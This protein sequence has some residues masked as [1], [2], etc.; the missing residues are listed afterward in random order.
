VYKGATEVTANPPSPIFRMIPPLF[1][2]KSTYASDGTG[3]RTQRRRSTI[4]RGD[5]APCG[6]FDMHFAYCGG[7]FT[8]ES[9]PYASD[10]IRRPAG[11]FERYARGVR[12]CP[13]KI[14]QSR[15]RPSAKR[16]SRECNST[17][18]RGEALLPQVL[19]RGFPVTIAVSLIVM[20]AVLVRVVYGIQYDSDDIPSLKL[21]TSSLSYVCRC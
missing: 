14:H 18:G 1:S 7:R 5:S 11:H 12:P 15:R 8:Q 2:P 20:R 9:R 17:P 16:H 3:R 13:P 4:A 6:V 10:A 19:G 21:L